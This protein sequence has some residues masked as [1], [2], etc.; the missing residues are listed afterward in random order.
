MRILEPVWLSV[1]ARYDGFFG[2]SALGF[3]PV[4]K[5]AG[6][7]PIGDFIGVNQRDRPSA[8]GVAC[9]FGARVVFVESSCDIVGDSGVQRIVRAT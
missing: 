1:I 3:D 6:G 5:T 7:G 2:F 4:L 9:T 8:A